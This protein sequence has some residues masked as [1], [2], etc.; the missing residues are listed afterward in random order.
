MTAR[1]RFWWKENYTHSFCWREKNCQYRNERGPLEQDRQK[2][3]QKMKK[4]K[5]EIEIAHKRIT[6]EAISSTSC[7]FSTLKKRSS[8]HMVDILVSLHK[9]AR[10]TGHIITQANSCLLLKRAGMALPAGPWTMQPLVMGVIPSVSPGFSAKLWWGPQPLTGRILSWPGTHHIPDLQGYEYFQTN[11]KPT[12]EE[13]KTNRIITTS[14]LTALGAPS[15]Q[16]ESHGLSQEK[17][18][19]QQWWKVGQPHSYSWPGSPLGSVHQCRFTPTA[20]AP[21]RYRY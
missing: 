12:N 7:N 18:C 2:Y 8:L 11:T 19:R 15:W 21:L 6:N 20:S 3:A 5:N 1:G 13:R 17:Q 4:I 16:L 10:T 14:C 9:V